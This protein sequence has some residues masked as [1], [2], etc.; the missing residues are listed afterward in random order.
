MNKMAALGKGYTNRSSRTQVRD[1]GRAFPG[2]PDGNNVT[3]S[4]DVGASKCNHSI[5]SAIARGGQ[6]QAAAHGS[7]SDA[8]TTFMGIANPLWA[9]IGEIGG[10]GTVDGT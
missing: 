4:T 9:R 5:G 3:Y 8:R 6:L 10:H 1:G 2:P 7:L